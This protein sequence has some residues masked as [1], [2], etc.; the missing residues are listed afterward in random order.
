M[1]WVPTSGIQKLARPEVGDLYPEGVVQQEI[2]R[3]QISG[4]TRKLSA[5]ILGGRGGTRE[6]NSP[7]Y[8]AF[9][10]HVAQGVDN[11]CRI[12]AD[13]LNGQ[14]AQVRYS[15]LEL[16]VS[17]KVENEDW[18]CNIPRVK[19]WPG[20]VVPWHDSQRLHSSW[21]VQ[22]NRTIPGCPDPRRTNV[23]FS[24]RAVCSF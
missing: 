6:V 16:P 15:C 23:F 21:N 5:T 9:R 19:R 24:A 10:V 8:N 1:D 11:L 14:R 12:I 7:V 20:N 3:L 4:D 17:R 18:A 13:T 2:L 22:C